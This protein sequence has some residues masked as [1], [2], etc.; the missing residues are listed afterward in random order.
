[1][2]AVA[3]HVKAGFEMKKKTGAA[4]T[5]LS[6]AN[7]TV[8]QQ[9]LML[10]LAQ[11]VKCKKILRILARMTGMRRFYGCL[12]DDTS[13]TFTLKNGVPQGS[14]IT[15]TLFNVYLSD[16]PETKSLKFGYADD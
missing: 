7:D 2:L 6:A 8:W 3:N 15:P 13:K 1:M 9:G 5:D 10:K 14:V 16:M 12:G 4:F 11:I